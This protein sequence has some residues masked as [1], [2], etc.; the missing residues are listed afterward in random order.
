LIHAASAATTACGCSGEQGVTGIRND[1]DGDAVAELVLHLVALVGRLERILR[2]PQI[3]KRRAV[4]L[5]HR[6]A[7]GALR[8]AH[9]RMPAVGG[10]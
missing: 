1:R 8:V 6:G 4:G 2:G 5:L 9:L 3:E 7:R 10:L